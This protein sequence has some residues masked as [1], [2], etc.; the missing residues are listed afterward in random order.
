MRGATILKAS[1]DKTRVLN[2]HTLM[3][4]SGEAGDT[5]QFAE[6][7]Q[8]NVQLYSMRNNMELSPAATAN[9]VRGELARALRSRKPYT[10][11]LLLGGYD[12]IADKPTLYWID[13]LASQA[14]LPYAAHGYAQYYCLSL[15]DKHHHPDINYE[16]GIKILRMCTEEL[17]RRLPIDFKG[18][19]VKVITKDGIKDVDYEDDVKVAIP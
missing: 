5:V 11:N 18:V 2:T 12:T 3:T 6:Y 15:L 14:S 10:V 4:F 16:Q 13:Y 9:F 17:K 1:D 8:A 19:L 7:I